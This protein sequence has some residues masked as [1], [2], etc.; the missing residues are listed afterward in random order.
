MHS[1]FPNVCDESPNEYI[2][3]TPVLECTDEPKN[4]DIF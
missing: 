4:E 3:R 2:S 1:V